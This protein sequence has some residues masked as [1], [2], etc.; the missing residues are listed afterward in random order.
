MSMYGTLKEINNH[1][2]RKQ[3]LLVDTLTEKAPILDVMPFSPASHGLWNVHEDVRNIASAAFVPLNSPLPAVDVTTDLKKVDLDIMGGQV[4]APEDQVRMF[5]G[6]EAYFAKKLPLLLANAGMA[7]EMRMY[8]GNFIPFAVAN[9]TAVS[10]GG[11]GNATASVV[12]VRFEREVTNGL[13]SPEGWKHEAM[14]DTTPINGGNLYPL[15]GGAFAGVLGYGM[16]LK[17]YFGMQIADKRTVGA[18]LNITE[19]A[20]PTVRQIDDLLA[21]VRATPKD[22]FLFMHVK[23]K[24]LLNAYKRDSLHITPENGDYKTSFANWD[25]IPIVCSYNILPFGETATAL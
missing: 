9:G 13:Y 16:R 19:T 14:L 22:T 2:A 25:G 24:N 6:R 10:A 7:A 21:D 8:Y 17:G 12:A 23:T 5:G 3:S 1:Y 18:I 11:T 15:Q 4:E 20:A